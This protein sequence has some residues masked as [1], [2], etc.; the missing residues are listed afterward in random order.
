MNAP[1]F[2][3]MAF[4]L[5]KVA[6]ATASELAKAAEA[7]LA[8]VGMGL[9]AEITI[10]VMIIG[11]N[12]K[13]LIAASRLEG[14]I[15]MQPTK[16]PK[17]KTVGPLRNERHEVFAFLIANGV[18]APQSYA[19]SYAC[20]A[21]AGTRVS[22][23]RLLKNVNVRHRIDEHRTEILRKAAD[24]HCAVVEQ[25]K[26]EALVQI[27]AGH[28]RAACRTAERLVHMAEKLEGDLTG[29]NCKP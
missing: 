27:K 24:T 22:A 25:I 9:V 26:A 13:L 20:E 28:L 15:A 14:A 21:D 18:S 29:R 19:R 4:N 8:F 5:A 10:G 1:A 16:Q 6:E 3:R 17:K 12:V 23:H 7:K 2:H 11:S